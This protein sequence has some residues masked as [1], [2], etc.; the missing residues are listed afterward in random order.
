MRWSF[1]VFHWK[2]FSVSDFSVQKFSTYPNP[3]DGTVHLQFENTVQLKK[4]VIRNL[5][6]KVV[7]KIDPANNTLGKTTIDLSRL[8]TGFYLLSVISSE[9]MV[10]RKILIE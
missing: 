6:G 1:V 8:P 9:G 4:I 5:K 3:S 2:T 10:S 7:K